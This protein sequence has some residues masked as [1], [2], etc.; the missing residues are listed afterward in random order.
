VAVTNREVG[1][2]V[3]CEFTFICDSESDDG[4]DEDEADEVGVEAES[5]GDVGVEESEEVEEEEEIAEAEVI[6][7]DEE[8]VEL[9][10]TVVGLEEAED[11][12]G[13]EEAPAPAG[14]NLSSAALRSSLLVN[15]QRSEDSQFPSQRKIINIQINIFR[16]LLNIPTILIGD[17]QCMFRICQARSGE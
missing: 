5:R 6:L 12:D 4:A 10:P 9:L 8:I 13:D 2:S 16:I 11:E 15:N 1:V 7:D 17:F 14:G 3:N